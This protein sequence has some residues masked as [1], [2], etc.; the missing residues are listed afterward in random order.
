MSEPRARVR[1]AS[2]AQQVKQAAKDE[3]FLR[4]TDRADLKTVMQLPAGR[5]LIWRVLGWTHV[6]DSIFETSA[7]I[8]Y[9]SGRQDVGHEL[10]Q[11]IAS[12]EPHLYLVMQQE[13]A[14]LTENMVEPPQT[15]EE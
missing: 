13:A 14:K 3:R 6:F 12:A 4:E 8:Y 9:N 5:R 10:Q 1:S 7:R 2:D 11:E 15:V